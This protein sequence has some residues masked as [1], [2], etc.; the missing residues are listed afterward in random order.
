MIGKVKRCQLGVYTHTC[1]TLDL[2]VF[3]FYILT[4]KGVISMVSYCFFAPSATR[5]SEN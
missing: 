4:I 5:W 3:C 1:K 2:H